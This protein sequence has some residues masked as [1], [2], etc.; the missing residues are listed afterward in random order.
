M[1]VELNNLKKHDHAIESCKKYPPLID[2]FDYRTLCIRLTND[3]F[4]NYIE[5]MLL[6][7][8]DA[9]QLKMQVDA[10]VILLNV[11][12]RQSEHGE[13]SNAF[14]TYEKA[15]SIAPQSEPLLLFHAMMETASIYIIH[16]NEDYM[17]KGIQLLKETRS[18]NIDKLSDKTD[19]NY[20]RYLDNALLSSFNIGIAYTLHL[21]EY[22]KAL[23]Y[24][25]FV[26]NYNKNYSIDSHIFSALAASE[27]G[28]IERAKGYLNGKKIETNDE[29]IERYLGCYRSLTILHW[30]KNEALSD[31]FNLHKNTSLEVKMDIYK[32]LSNLTDTPAELIGLRLF[33]KTVE[34]TLEPELKKKAS[35][36]ASNTELKRLEMESELKSQIL[37]KE[38]ELQ[39]ALNAENTTRVYFLLTLMFALI[40]LLS[41]IWSQFRQKKKMALQFKQLSYKDSLTQ[42]GN[43][44]FL[45][46]NI[47]KELQ[48]I[49]RARHSDE[50]L[51]LGFFIFDIDHFKKI[52]DQ[53][54]HDSGDKILVELS[55][56]IN[57]IIRGTDLLIRWGGEEF[58]CI[59][60]LKSDHELAQLGERIK[61]VVNK[62]PFKL[63]NGEPIIV[64]CTIGAAKYPF[65]F[66]S[67]TENNWEQLIKLADL[68]LYWGKEKSR[69]CWVIINNEKITS[70]EELKAVLGEPL[71][72][73]IDNKILSIT[74][75]C[76]SQ[77]NSD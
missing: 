18:R 40:M 71:Q 64:T 45:E 47:T 5:S 32:R 66:N 20:K 38:K 72:S 16:G 28:E 76:E 53:Y 46:S 21:H 11:G 13:I 41:F 7:F 42:L 33:K 25:D 59:A 75:S 63:I 55:N 73:S 14:A 3:T 74:S 19:N 9:Y 56:R 62:H 36:A 58:L 70:D 17:R 26:N 22:E 48:F 37:L 2:D 49:D 6:A 15:I 29:T 44:R 24:F 77:I 10:V 51:I 54:G 31:C 23:P 27:N 65:L 68:A 34:N 67:Y 50:N 52:N 60:R 57:N 12:W 30:N 1:A 8:Q 43:R 35:K 39:A 4:E 61:N 69:D